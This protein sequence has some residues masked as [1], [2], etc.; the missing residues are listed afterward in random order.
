MRNFVFEGLKHRR[1]AV[2]EVDILAMLLRKCLICLK[3]CD[4]RMTQRVVC[5]QHTSD[6]GR[7]MGLP[8]LNGYRCKEGAQGPT[9][10][11]RGTPQMTV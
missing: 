6:D 3:G 5:H 4:W 7:K 1:L 2:I 11:S 10:K 9:I 8:L